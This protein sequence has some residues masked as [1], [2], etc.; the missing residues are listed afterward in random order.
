M[1]VALLVEVKLLNTAISVGANI[2]PGVGGVMLFEIGPAIR[3]VNFTIGL[4]VGKGVK[5]VCQ[6]M[7]WEILWLVIATI[8]SPVHI[9]ADRAVACRRRTRSA[10]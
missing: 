6:E 9:V 5:T 3:E 10:V 1:P 7:C 8:Y 4:D 2:I